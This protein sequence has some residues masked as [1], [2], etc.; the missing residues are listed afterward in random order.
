MSVSFGWSTVGHSSNTANLFQ[1]AQAFRMQLFDVYVYIYIC[2]Y[3]YVYSCVHVYVH[4]CGC[5]ADTY[6]K[7]AVA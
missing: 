3:I 2:I 1:M 4:R 5:P 6:P 7:D